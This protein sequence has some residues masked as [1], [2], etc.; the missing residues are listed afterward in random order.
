MMNLFWSLKSYRIFN[1]LIH[2]EI[3][4]TK[5]KLA[6]LFLLTFSLMLSSCSSDDDT[7]NPADN[8][9]E[10][11]QIN[12]EASNATWIITY[13]YDTDQDETSH[14]NGYEFTFA[15]DGTITATDGMNTRTGTWSVTDESS[16][17]DSSSGDD[18]IDFNISFT[19]PP[20]FE[21]LSDDWDIVSHSSTKI[22]LI[23][24]SGGNGGTD[25]LTFEIE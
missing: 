7:N 9:A 16:S 10:I 1:Q 18:D 20:D 15:S 25:Y 11:Q 12:N 4:K 13:F 14:F 19:S 5:F 6:M 21:E 2:T 24:V 8:S 17:D 23:D 3:M 22:E